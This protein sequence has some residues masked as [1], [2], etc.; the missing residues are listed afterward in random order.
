MAQLP[1]GTILQLASAKSAAKAVSGISN[2]AEAVVSCTAHGFSAGD[3]VILFSGWG[4]L[5]KRSF[6]IKTILTD[7][8][9]LEGMD[10]TNITFYPPGTGGGTVE[11]VSTWTQVTGIVNVQTQGGEPKTV[12]YKFMESD[13][14]YSI[15]DG[16]TASGY[17]LDIDAD[18]IGTAGYN[19]LKTLTEVQTDTVARFINRSGS[20]VLQPCTVALNEAVRMTDGQINVVN[21]SLNGNNRAFR[22]AA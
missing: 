7:S 6:R 3:Y 1:T 4:R 18:Q 17:T 2:A 11:K 9:V 10:T 16:F 8:F 21:C 15:N 12:N 19:A 22:Y 5:N 13:V 14:E 20:I